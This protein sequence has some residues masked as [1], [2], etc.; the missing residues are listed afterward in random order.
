[1]TGSRAL[2]SLPLNLRDEAIGRLLMALPAPR[3]FPTDERDYLTALADQAAMIIDNWQLLR[4]TQDSLEEARILYEASSR[5]ADVN[6]AEDVLHTL[7][8]AAAISEV[9]V[10]QLFLLHGG[11]IPALGGASHANPA[12]DRRRDGGRADL[13]GKPAVLPEPGHCGAGHCSPGD[14]RGARR[15]AAVRRTA[16]APL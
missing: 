2:V 11:A 3:P 10:A 14:G 4:Q 5:I 1:V 13:R 12:G 16:P 7:A 8:R 9:S 6:S 15:R